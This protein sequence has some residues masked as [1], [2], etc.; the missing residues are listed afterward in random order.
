MSFSGYL[1]IVFK[2]FHIDV[3]KSGLRI[4]GSQQDQIYNFITALPIMVKKNKK[5]E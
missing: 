1:G 2:Y 5:N 3:F 4:T